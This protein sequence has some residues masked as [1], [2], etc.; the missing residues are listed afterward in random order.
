VGERI[1]PGERVWGLGSK[2]RERQHRHPFAASPT[3]DDGGPPARQHPR[4]N[5]MCW[6]CPRPVGPEAAARPMRR[7]FRRGDHPPR[8]RAGGWRPCARKNLSP[9]RCSSKGKGRHSPATSFANTDPTNSPCRHYDA[10]GRKSARKPK[11]T[12]TAF[13]SSMAPTTAHHH[14]LL[15]PP[16]SQEK[17][18]HQNPYHA[19]QPRVEWLADPAIRKVARRPICRDL[20]QVPLDL[21]WNNVSQGRRRGEAAPPP[22]HAG[23][24][25]KGHP[26]PGI[27][28]R[29]RSRSR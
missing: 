17:G 29:G 24:N 13:V 18:K 25:E 16:L 14:G 7:P 26:S 11:G 19:A 6:S 23:A 12:L 8:Q 4:P 20:R 10:L 1:K 22:R 21:A 27:S 28:S 2:R 9:R 15:P 5:H 3:R